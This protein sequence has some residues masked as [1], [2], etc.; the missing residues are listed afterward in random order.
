MPARHDITIYQGANFLLPLIWKTAAGVPIDLTGY[1]AAMQIRR[2]V[3]SKD[4]LHS[5]STE[6]GAGITLGGVAG[7]ID[8]EIPPEVSSDFAFRTGV[9][10]LELTPPDGKTIRLIEGK[11][12]VSLEVT[13]PVAPRT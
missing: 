4:P 6:L 10:D 5:M 13:R 2:N 3:R 8:V 11:V 9:F 7:T 12:T 1:T